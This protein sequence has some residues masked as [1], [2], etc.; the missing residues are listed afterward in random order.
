M[1][2]TYK[3]RV[4]SSILPSTCSATVGNLLAEKPYILSPSTGKE[5][6]SFEQDATFNDFDVCIVGLG[7]HHFEHHAE[8]LRKLARRVKKGG[9][10]GIVDLFPSQKVF[11][12]FFCFLGRV[13]FVLCIA[14]HIVSYTNMSTYSIKTQ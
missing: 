8:A 12:P 6:Y 2:A 14:L 10:V 7:F 9:V 11:P 13:L 3:S 5:D 1:I 4:T